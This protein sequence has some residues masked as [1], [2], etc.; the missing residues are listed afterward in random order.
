M[1]TKVFHRISDD[2]QLRI[3]ITVTELA[4]VPEAYRVAYMEHDDGDLEL[5]TSAADYVRDALAELASLNAQIEKL[6]TEG[7]AKVELERQRR[8][9][10]AVDVALRDSLKKAGVKADLF[11]G[12]MAQLKKENEFEAETSDDGKGFVVLA[13]TPFGLHSVDAVVGRLVGEEGAWRERRTAP[14][15]GYFSSLLAGLKEPR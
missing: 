1:A 13:R 12:A 3:K 9:D 11:E 6:K 5:S 2:L 8:R 14:S 7:P 10:D 15:A 4:S